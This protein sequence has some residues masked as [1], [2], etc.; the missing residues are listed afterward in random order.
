MKKLIVSTIIVCVITLI[1]S[2]GSSPTK[3]SGISNNAE[4]S[5]DN[6]TPQWVKDGGESSTNAERTCAVGSTDC[7]VETLEHD[8]EKA[9][10]EART[11][12][13]RKLGTNLLHSPS[14][15]DTYIDSEKGTC[16]VLV[17]VPTQTK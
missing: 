7:S 5:K 17:C 9:N 3:D 12:L 10:M 4:T 2:C 6:E 11:N 1:I 8:L 16:F 14:G 13:A 15:E